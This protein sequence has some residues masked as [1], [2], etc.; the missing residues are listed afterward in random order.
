[1]SA[2]DA[3]IAAFLTQA[4]WGKAVRAPLAGDASARRYER[5][6]KGSR[7]AVLMDAPPEPGE[8]V[9]G[10]QGAL[11]ASGYSA[12]ARLAVDCRPFVAIATYLSQQGLSAPKIFAADIAQGLLLLEDLG[13]DLFVRLLGETQDG[14][15]EEQLYEAAVDLLAAA[16]TGARLDQLPLADG[17]H[18]AL[19][20]YEPSVYQIEAD[21]LI[22]WYLPALRGAGPNTAERSAYHAAWTETLSLL[23]TA[24]P[25]LCLR[26]YHAGN[27]IWLPDRAGPARVGLLDF[28]DGLLGSPAYDLVSLLQDAR[29]DV[30]P[31]LEQ[32]MLERYITA[33]RGRAGFDERGFRL[34][35]AILGAQRNAKIVGIFTRLS[36]RD[37]KP[38]YLRHMPRVWRHLS[39]DL[40]HPR[41]APLRAWFDSMI[42][43]AARAA[44]PAPEG[45]F[46]PAQK[47]GS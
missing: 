6:R 1:M 40:A 7:K 10:P 26:D 47:V 33:S 35:Y 44:I 28:Q 38:V 43:A 19:K 20:R 25:V 24:S 22:D 18:F 42:P 41:L 21:L 5:V 39:A 9:T 32:R 23:D 11:R 30:S 46:A 27:L 36:R 45:G 4:G 29:R 31:Q 16:H 15:G 14:A 13:D 17:S 3:A 12:A 37:G 2:R 34:A 8:A